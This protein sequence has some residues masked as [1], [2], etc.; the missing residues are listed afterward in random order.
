MPHIAAVKF[1]GTQALPA[2]ALEAAL[3]KVAAGSEYTE[4]GFREL[5]DYNVRR[6]YEEQGLLGVSFPRIAGAKDA[7]GGVVPGATLLDAVLTPI[8]F[9]R[10]GEKPLARLLEDARAKHGDGQIHP[11]HAY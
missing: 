5:L 7:S 4:S 6:L 3:A 9:L 8:L 2:A 10:F 1:E 11:T